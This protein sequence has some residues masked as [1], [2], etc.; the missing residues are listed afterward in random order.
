MMMMTMIMPEIKGSILFYSICIVTKMPTTEAM[1]NVKKLPQ[2]W[3]MPDIDRVQQDWMSQPND[4]LH[5]D[6]DKCEHRD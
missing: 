5:R 1:L 4:A 2:Q 6:D 3:E